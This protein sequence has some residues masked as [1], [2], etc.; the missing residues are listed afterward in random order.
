MTT[1]VTIEVMGPLLLAALLL[2]PVQEPARPAAPA[3]TKPYKMNLRISDEITLPDLAGAQHALFA[4]SEGKLLVLVFW[5]FQDPVSR[6]YVDRLQRLQRE[7]AEHARVF[8]IDSNKDELVGGAADP[9]QKIKSYF[10]QEKIEL[11]LLIDRDNKIADDF[12]AIANG[13]AFVVDANRTLR[14]QGGIDD[15]P[16]GEREKKNL[17]ITGWLLPALETLQ[18][19]EKIPTPLTITRPSGRPIKRVPPK[20]A[21]APGAQR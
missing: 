15:D 20:Q 9:L 10:E 19:G 17:P 11:T 6:L 7:H 18:R 12:A 21:S 3:P 4:E 13:H 1:S 14:Y 16:R 8:L 5:S 2:S